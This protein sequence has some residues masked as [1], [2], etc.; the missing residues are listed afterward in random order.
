MS[1]IRS[2]LGAN[3]T[4]HYIGH[5]HWINYVLAYG[6]LLVAVL[7]GLGGGSYYQSQNAGADGLSVTTVAFL[8][9]TIGLI[10][11]LVI[12]IP[13]W[14]TEIGVTNQ[15]IIYKTGFISRSTQELQLRSVEEVN[16]QQS[17]LGRIFNYGKI[18]IHGT[19]EEEIVLPNLG[20]AVTLRKALQEAIGAAQNS[21]RPVSAGASPQRAPVDG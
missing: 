11:F 10:I 15:R 13:I 7:L 2:S 20:D 18:E 21:T 16:M 19:G 6:T 1:Y 5:F 8:P 9:I 4:V 12:M 14:T 17:V 3:E